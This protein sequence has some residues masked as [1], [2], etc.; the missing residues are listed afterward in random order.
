MFVCSLS[1]CLEASKADK[2]FDRE[3]SHGV[4]RLRVRVR[5]LAISGAVSREGEVVEREG[6]VKVR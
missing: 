4:L 5:A 1:C 3:L 2:P 6:R